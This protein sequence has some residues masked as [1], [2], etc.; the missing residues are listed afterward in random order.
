MNV[1]TFI[2]VEKK[3]QAP[4]SRQGQASCLSVLRTL[5]VGEQL[6]KNSTQHK[7]R[8]V[9][10]HPHKRICSKN[11]LTV[12]S[13]V[14]LM[15]QQVILPLLTPTKCHGIESRNDEWSSRGFEYPSGLGDLK[16][17]YSKAE[18]MTEATVAS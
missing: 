14:N 7:W 5:D 9:R 18:Y 17:L 12:S 3:L 1:T 11:H 2:K 6:G 8:F 4:P 15:G 16:N 10:L 13:Q